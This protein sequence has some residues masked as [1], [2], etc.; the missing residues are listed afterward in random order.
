MW[1]ILERAA[2]AAI[3]ALL[4]ALAPILGDRLAELEH[5]VARVATTARVPT[6]FASSCS[7]PHP[8]R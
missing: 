1:R 4:A 8:T 3:L 2:I 7:P 5:A 6:W